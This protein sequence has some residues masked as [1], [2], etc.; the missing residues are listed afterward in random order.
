MVLV[1]GHQPAKVLQPG[2]ESLDLPAAVVATERAA[3][4]R[5]VLPIRP[6]WRNELDPALRL[7]PRIERIGVVRSVA[8]QAFGAA[9][10]GEGV[11]G[12]FDEGDFIR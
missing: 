12:R 9:E 7:E 6:V 2:E 3:I 5:D 11:E 10:G 8:D 1:A 4:L